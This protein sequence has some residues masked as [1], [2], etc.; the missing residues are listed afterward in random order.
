MRLPFLALAAFILSVL[1]TEIVPHSWIIV[2]K[3]G[4]STADFRAH[5]I[6]VREL[7][8]QSRSN[9]AGVKYELQFLNMY[10]GEFDD[11]TIQAIRENEMVDYVE[12]NQVWRIPDEPVVSPAP[13]EPT[14]PA[15]A[16]RLMRRGVRID[17]RHGLAS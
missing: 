11:A 7:H 8:A 3:D 14:V 10:T 17:D 9:L 12:P 6:W 16:P 1:A 2:L 15:P 4:I 5:L 13:M